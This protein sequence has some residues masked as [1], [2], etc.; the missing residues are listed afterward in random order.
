M[1]FNI[2]ATDT[3][4]YNKLLE[5]VGQYSGFAVGQGLA[6]STTLTVTVKGLKTI[7]GVIMTGRS[8][9]LPYLA[10]TSDNT[11]TA[12]TGSGDII[13]WLAWGVPKI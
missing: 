12:T 9:T 3:T 10:S 2:T 11:F 6:V 7:Y 8:T 5:N 13:D 1:A 4:T